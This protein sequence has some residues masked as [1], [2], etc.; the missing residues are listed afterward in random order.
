MAGG[1]GSSGRCNSSEARCYRV[2]VFV[3]CSVTTWKV[4]EGLKS[5]Q[6][7]SNRLHFIILKFAKLPSNHRQINL[8]LASTPQENDPCSMGGSRGLFAEIWWPPLWC[9][10]RVCVPP[11]IAM[12]HKAWHLSKASQ[13]FSPRVSPY[14]PLFFLMLLYEPL[15]SFVPLYLSQFT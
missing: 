4:Q 15:C 7:Y 10:V 5:V 9:Q 6:T 12:W 13:R 8:S 2:L 3:T 11:W 1:R 14:E